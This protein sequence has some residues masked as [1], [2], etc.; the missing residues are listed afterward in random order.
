MN[1]AASADGATLTARTELW[2]LAMPFIRNR[3]ILGYGYASS[4]FI[5]LQVGGVSWDP[6]HMHNGFLEALY[7][8]GFLGLFL[9]LAIPFEAPGNTTA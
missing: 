4:R 8:N 6:G 2:G 7:N 3:P 1:Y 5:S 9:M